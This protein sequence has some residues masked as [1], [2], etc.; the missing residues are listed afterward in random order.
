MDREVV[1]KPIQ[2]AG[3]ESDVMMLGQQP[4]KHG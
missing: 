1:R 3:E 4:V 2:Q